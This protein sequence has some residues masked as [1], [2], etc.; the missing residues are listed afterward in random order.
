MTLPNM[1]AMIC[2]SAALP[3]GCSSVPTAKGSVAIGVNPEV[4]TFPGSQHLTAANAVHGE[5]AAPFAVCWRVTLDVLQQ[6][7]YSIQ[8]ATQK[9]GRIRTLEKEFTGPTYPWRESYS[10][11]LIPMKNTKT[12]VKVQR[13]VKVHRRILLVGPSFWM[14]KLS[15]GQRENLLI[16]SIA[17]QLEPTGVKPGEN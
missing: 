15:N 2:F 9:G 7:G 8:E 14:A 11:W 12:G 5:L 6:S 13:L 16:E 1:L 4:E 17:R 3:L 10:I